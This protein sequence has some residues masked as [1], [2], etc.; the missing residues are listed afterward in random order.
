[1][2]GERLISGILAVLC[3]AALLFGIRV[4][5]LPA[6]LPVSDT[7]GEVSLVAAAPPPAPSVPEPPP[8]E[9]PRPEPPK[10]THPLPAPPRRVAPPASS[11]AAPAATPSRTT[12]SSS[13]RPRFNPKPSYPPE[14]RRLRQEGQVL[15]DV[16][17]SADGRA[18]SVSVRR[19]SGFP[20]LDA[21]AQE[22]VRRWTF[23]PARV[24]GLAVATR[25]E[26][27]VTFKLSP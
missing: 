2:S 23:D 21:A 6:P 8:P 16:E 4:G 14:A 12:A 22:A 20:L 7:A 3:H 5:S 26:V 9:V 15:L 10:P 24:A 13:L 27:P 17:V 19:S 1:M 25:S 11:A 18:T